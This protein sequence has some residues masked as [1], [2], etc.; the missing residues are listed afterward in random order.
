[1]VPNFAAQEYNG[2]IAFARYV[3]CCFALENGKHK[4]LIWKGGKGSL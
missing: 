2:H 3:H 1:M 4:A